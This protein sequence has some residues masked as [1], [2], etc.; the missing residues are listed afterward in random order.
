[1]QS[2]PNTCRICFDGDSANDT[3][4]SPCTCK[5]SSKYIHKGCL[6]EWRRRG[7]KQ[8]FQCQTCLYVYRM[9]SLKYATILRADL[10]AVVCTILVIVSTVVVVAYF[11]TF[12]SWLLFGV[13]IGGRASMALTSKIVFQS[14]LVIGFVFMVICLIVAAL[15]D[16][17]PTFDL[18]GFFDSTRYVDNVVLEF[19]G[20]TF[21]LTGFAL[22]VVKV[23]DSVKFY[24]H[25]RL[26]QLSHRVLDVKE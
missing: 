20:Y 3:L 17:G 2:E 22:F 7:H 24:L 8:A 5:G 11:L 23:Y 16:D 9:S 19:F 14:I 21:S 12:M 26:L 15:E 4:F 18:R 1:M 25:T 13:A 10:T 6:E